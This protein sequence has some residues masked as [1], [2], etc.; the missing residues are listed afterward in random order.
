M[1]KLLIVVDYQNDFVSGSLGFEAAKR[2]EDAVC[3]KI[4]AYQAAGDDVV[5]T[6]D[7]HGSSYAD[8]QEGR[9][10]AGGAL[11][12]RHAGLGTLRQGCRSAARLPRLRKPRC[13]A[14]PICLIGSGAGNTAASSFAVW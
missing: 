9:E 13:S 10:A 1:K 8:T 12:A 14:A 11:P 5:Y 2:I 7:T 6:L 3:E 4:R